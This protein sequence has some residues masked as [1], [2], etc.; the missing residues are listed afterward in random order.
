M[1]NC[2]P[3][4]A[5]DGIECIDAMIAS[6]GVEAVKDHCCCTALKYIWRHG[7]K[8]KSREVEDIEKAIWYLEK[9]VELSQ[10]KQGA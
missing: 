10:E 9:Y 5:T 8:D 7:R 1:V 2:P 4:Y 3:H 6:Q